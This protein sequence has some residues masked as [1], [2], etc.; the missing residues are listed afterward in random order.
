M[1][2]DVQIIK[3][4]IPIIRAGIRKAAVKTLRD[5]ADQILRGAKKNIVA[6]DVIDTGNMLNSGYVRTNTNDGWPST[7][8]F[9]GMRLP[10]PKNELEIQINFAAS[11]S[12][13]IHE[14]TVFMAGSPFLT[15][16]V[17]TYQPEIMRR[18]QANL[19]GEI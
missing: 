4:R 18:F 15:D 5:G 19:R 12:I 13:W 1:S 7:T 11:Y 10:S 3:N 9:P 2:Y 6:Y 14:G 17:T 8:M 16:A